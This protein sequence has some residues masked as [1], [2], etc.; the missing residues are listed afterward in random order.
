MSLP[1][2]VSRNCARLRRV[3]PVFWSCGLLLMLLLGR[4]ERYWTGPLAFLLCACSI[5]TGLAGLVALLFSEEPDGDKEHD[6][7]GVVLGLAGV[8]GAFATALGAAIATP[9]H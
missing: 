1:P 8:L 5:T 7:R 2:R 6:P 9:T 3:S 4:A